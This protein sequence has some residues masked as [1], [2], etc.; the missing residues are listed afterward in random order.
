MDEERLKEF[1]RKEFEKMP[2]NIKEYYGSGQI[3]KDMENI[4][5]KL[6]IDK[7]YL[8]ELK[9]LFAERLMRQEELGSLNRDLVYITTDKKQRLNIMKEMLDLMK[10]YT[11][12]MQE[13]RRRQE[14]DGSIDF[15]REMEEEAE[16]EFQQLI[17]EA[18]EHAYQLKEENEG[19]EQVAPTPPP[20]PNGVSAPTK[21]SAT[22]DEVGKIKSVSPPPPVL[23]KEDQNQEID[24][25]TRNE[26]ERANILKAIENPSYESEDKE[27]LKGFSDEQN[28]SQA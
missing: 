24:E 12:E 1:Y 7:G 2:E 15:V 23:I 22:E 10:P 20:K 13:I 6:S 3:E 19:S 8:L 5:E 21:N 17:E 14:E 16:K 28:K 26:K 18:K 27:T 25:S 11:K 9:A 4:C